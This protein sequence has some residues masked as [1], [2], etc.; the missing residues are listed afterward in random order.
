M[1][2]LICGEDETSSYNFYSELKNKFL[3]KGY[4]VFQGDSDNFFDIIAK[5]EYSSTL[6]GQKNAFFFQGLLKKLGKNKDF[7]RL[8]E[9]F[10]KSSADYL[11]IIDLVDEKTALKFLDSKNVVNFSY[12]D[13]LWSLLDNFS[14]AK[15]E[16]FLQKF[17]EV[18]KNTAIELI[19][20]MLARRTREL[21]LAKEDQLQAT[22]FW[23]K[24]KLKKQAQDWSLAKLNAFIDHFHTIDL[25][26]KTSATPYSLK[27]LLEIVFYFGL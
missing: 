3:A 27:D 18:S 20:F 5:V 14:P 24:N 15:K 2:K 17:N 11:V 12:P 23:L 8:L 25:R 19:F 4:R 10:K 6:F 16:F 7:L 22:P 26:V 21:I 1:I 13:T 9:F